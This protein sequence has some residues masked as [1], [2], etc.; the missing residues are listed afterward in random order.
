MKKGIV[1]YSINSCLKL[2]LVDTT[3]R[4]EEVEILLQEEN[5]FYLVV[6]FN[7]GIYFCTLLN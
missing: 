2:V 4:R 5:C 3:I 7:G 1:F 6:T